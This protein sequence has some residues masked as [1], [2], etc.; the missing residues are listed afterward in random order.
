MARLVKKE[1]KIGFMKKARVASKISI[2]AVVVSLVGFISTGRD[3]YGLD[4]LGGYKA[5]VRLTKPATQGEIKAAVDEV[6]PGAQV[7]SVLGAAN[8]DGSRSTQFVIKVKADASGSDESDTG[9]VDLQ[10][11]YEQPLK[12]ALAGWLR[13]DFVTGLTLT[14][15]EAA[16]STDIAATLNFEGPVTPDSVNAALGFLGSLEVTSGSGDSVD[17]IARMPGLG[18]DQQFI[19]QRMFSALSAGGGAGTLPEPS[20]PFLES[21]TI[22]SR[23]G[24]ELRDSAIRAIILSFIVI[25]LYI[26]IRFKEY[27]YGIAAIVALAHDVAITLGIVALAHSLG[28]VEIEIDLAMIAAFLT[29][30]GYSLNDTIVLFDRVRENLPRIDKPL[31]E[32][33]DISVN[34]TLSRTMLTSITTLLVLSVIFYFS[35]GEQHVLEGFSFAMI[36]G[37]LVGTYS[38]IFVASPVVALLARNKEATS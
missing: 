18:L 37:V 19:V 28:A 6:F 32:V 5:Q 1:T 35:V 27:R 15:D 24:I 20:E 29:I 11:S 8:A 22:G 38:S 21:A 34:Q 30:V 3:S 10:D 4:F 25:V 36:I 33:L 2:V 31:E 17:L 7:I 14:E 23:V 13:P 16:A 9:D 26:R 12:A